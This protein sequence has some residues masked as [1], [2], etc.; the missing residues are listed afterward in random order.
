MSDV[1]ELGNI[2]E[3][4]SLVLFKLLNVESFLFSEIW[5][6]NGGE[7]DETDEK[8]IR[9]FNLLEEI[10]FPT[11]LIPAKPDKKFENYLVFKMLKMREIA[12]YFHD[13]FIGFVSL[14]SQFFLLQY[15]TFKNISNL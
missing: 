12:M 6:K 4:L 2:I 8:L 11:S 14:Y 13:F 10:G 3:S 15:C 9:L 5:G 1:I 7:E